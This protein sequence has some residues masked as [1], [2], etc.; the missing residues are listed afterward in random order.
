MGQ[1][2]DRQ[3]PPSHGN[4]IPL[5]VLVLAVAVVAFVIGIAIPLGR[6]GHG[7]SLQ[8]ART[9]LPAVSQTSPPANPAIVAATVTAGPALA[10]A[11]TNPAPAAPAVARAPSDLLR[12]VSK[13]SESL[14]A[15]YVPPDLQA[16]PPGFSVPAGLLLRHEALLAFEQ[17]SAA[18][19]QQGIFF[20]AVSTYR[21]YDDQVTVYANEVAQFGKTQADH[22]SAMPGRSE[23]Q[24]GTAID[25]ST[26]RLN[27]ALDDSFAQ[28]P[29]GIWLAQH[30]VEYGFV[31][32]YP[33]GKEQITGY[34]YEPWHYRYLGLDA[35]RRIVASGKTSTEVLPTIPLAATQPSPSPTLPES[36]GCLVALTN[37]VGC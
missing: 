19:Q 7:Q 35:A 36:G 8:A 18:A 12:F 33:E 2:R 34:R 31:L 32:S 20:V 10:T 17:M 9:A 29:E 21:S 14:P 3:K 11:S 22:E 27:Y 15:E 6:R 37:G 1:E 13:T 30:A 16:L 28:M 25:I 24:L 4:G 5:P 26:P 23:H